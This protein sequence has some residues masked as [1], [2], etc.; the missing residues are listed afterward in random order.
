MTLSQVQMAE[1][2]MGD[3][4]NE[5]LSESQSMSDSPKIQK[6]QEKSSESSA[7]VDNNSQ[8]EPNRA[9]QRSQ[10]NPAEGAE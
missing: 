7:M 3:S 6:A 5:G 10:E 4:S 2:A 1:V 9:D 8:K